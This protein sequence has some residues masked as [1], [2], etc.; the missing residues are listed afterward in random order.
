MADPNSLP[1]QL[2]KAK[3]TARVL[4]KRLQVACKD[5]A[6]DPWET[7]ILSVEAAALEA[8]RAEKDFDRLVEQMRRG[9]VVPRA[10]RAAKAPRT[11]KAHV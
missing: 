11:V 10:A 1:Y 7:P 9:E 2:Q 4:R 3:A 5:F 6:A 8:R